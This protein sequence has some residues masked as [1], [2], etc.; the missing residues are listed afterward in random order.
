VRKK[1]DTNHFVTALQDE[2]DKNVTG[3]RAGGE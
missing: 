3:D 1:D 2:K